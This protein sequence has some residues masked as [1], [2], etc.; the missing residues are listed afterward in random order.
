[1]IFLL[2]TSVTH[3]T[4]CYLVRASMLARTAFLGGFHSSTMVIE[5]SG[6][7]ITP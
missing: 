5:S 3:A 6:W 7:G 1:M 2:T 4:A